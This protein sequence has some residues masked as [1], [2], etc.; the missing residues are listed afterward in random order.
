MQASNIKTRLTSAPGAVIIAAALLLVALAES[1][2][3]PWAPYFPLFAIIALILPL[4]LKTFKFGRFGK[5]F[6]SSLPLILLCWGL[7][8]LWDQTSSGAIF[9]LIL[10]AFGIAKDPVYSLPAAIDALFAAISA[11]LAIPLSTA[12][13]V[14]AAFALVWAPVGEELFYRGFLFG[15]LRARHGFWPAALASSAFFGLRHMLPFLFLLPQLLIL[16]AITWAAATFGFG[17]L[18]CHLYEKTQSL[19][20]SMI[21]HFLVNVVGMLFM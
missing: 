3:F 11:H 9:K 12:Q 21:G 19:Y 13:I 17:L 7:F 16:P 15:A 18:S 1:V 2:L 8:I 5:V 20:P 10:G 14:F 4:V 6:A